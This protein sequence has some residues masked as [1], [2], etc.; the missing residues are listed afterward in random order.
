MATIWHNGT[1]EKIIEIA[2]NVKSF[3]L[4]VDEVA[5][6]DF[7]PGQFIT[8]D[9]PV[10]EKRLYRWR[11]YSIASNPN[12]NII[13]L[14]IV[15]NPTGLATTYLFDNVHIGDKLKFKGPE[16][17]F[18]LKENLQSDIVLIA[19]GTGVAPF[20]S[21]LQNLLIQNRFEHNIHLIFGTRYKT[22]V[23]YEKEFKSLAAKYP[24]FKYDV[25]LSKEVAEGYHHGYLHDLYLKKYEDNTPNTQ[26]YIC[27]WSSM[28]DE[29]VANLI[30]KLKKDKSQI[31][32]ELY[33]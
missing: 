32:Y 13:E 20:R 26:F 31:I 10:S 33:G 22:G 29:C 14:C 12:K 7:V 17:G 9:L 30:M 4:Q 6:F 15:R 27:G 2:P 21:M 28:I 11:S 24:N 8:L 19:T 23:L 5:I 16:G 1:I 3:T 25:A 18:V